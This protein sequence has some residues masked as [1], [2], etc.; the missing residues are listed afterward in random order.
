MVVS[1]SGIRVWLNPALSEIFSAGSIDDGFD[2]SNVSSCF[3]FNK[4]SNS[5]A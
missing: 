2:G 3:C 1:R 4:V 5:S